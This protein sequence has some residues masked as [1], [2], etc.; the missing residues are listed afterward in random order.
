MKD[1]D[2]AG[3]RKIA[4]KATQGR[5]VFSP[6]DGSALDADVVFALDDAGEEVSTVTAW[7]DA[8]DAEHIA[9]FDPPTVLALLDLIAEQQAELAEFREQE[10]ASDA[11]PC[12][13]E[14][15]SW[16][17]FKPEQVDSYQI[18]CDRIGN[19]SKH[20]DSHTGATW[21]AVADD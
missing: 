5:W 21:E 18:R 13:A 9:A 8:N 11:R 10:A 7:L 15:P 6:D 3:L 4:G 20:R 19:H 14:V 1:L 2:L 16:E 12:S 17:L